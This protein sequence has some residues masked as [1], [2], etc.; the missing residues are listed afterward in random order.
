MDL[1][2]EGKRDKEI[3]TELGIRPRTVVQRISRVCDKLGAFTRP[4]AA[5]IYVERRK[6]LESDEVQE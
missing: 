1:L 5:A 3:A 2:L 4:Q 6:A